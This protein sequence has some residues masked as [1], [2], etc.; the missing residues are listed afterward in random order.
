MEGG[1]LVYLYTGSAD[2]EADVTFYRDHLGGEVVWHIRSGGT[3]VAAIRLGEG[4]LV[5]LADHRP[6]PRVL[7]IWAVADL[8]GAM[9]RLEET[10]WKG[11]ATEVEVPDGPCLILSDPS[12]NEIALMDQIRPNVLETEHDHH[13]EG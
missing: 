11:S 13:E 4:P 10:G 5:L 9:A 12:G 8:E 7:Q 3:E 2:V 6:V 1:R